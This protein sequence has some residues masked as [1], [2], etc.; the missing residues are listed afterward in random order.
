MKI[1][2]LVRYGA[3]TIAALTGYGTQS[4]LGGGECHHS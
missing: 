4:L 2:V 1:A 3:S